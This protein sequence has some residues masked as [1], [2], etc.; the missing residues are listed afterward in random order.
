MRHVQFSFRPSVWLKHLHVCH[1]LVATSRG[2]SF[3]VCWHERRPCCISYFRPCSKRTVLHWSSPSFDYHA[4]LHP[5]KILFELEAQFLFRGQVLKPRTQRPESVNPAACLLQAA[6]CLAFGVSVTDHRVLFGPSYRSPRLKTKGTEVR[7]SW[8]LLY[9]A[10]CTE[11]LVTSSAALE[12]CTW[13]T[14]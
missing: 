12:K 5:W 1:Q 6:S 13:S 11:S 8:C 4:G 10:L 2:R 14:L 7:T 3:L 9:F